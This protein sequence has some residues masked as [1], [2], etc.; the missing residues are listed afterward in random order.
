MGPFIPR[1]SSVSTEQSQSAVDFVLKN[2][3]QFPTARSSILVSLY[4][5]IH[6]K[7][8]APAFGN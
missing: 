7:G 5:T 2:F 6:K 8:A 3:E 4:D 1:T